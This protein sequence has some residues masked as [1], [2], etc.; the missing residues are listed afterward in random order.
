[1]PDLNFDTVEIGSRVYKVVGFYKP[2]NKKKADEDLIELINTETKQ[3][4]ITTY[5][6]SIY[7]TYTH[8][9]ALKDGVDVTGQ[10]EVKF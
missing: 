4:I 10:V 2:L 8:F 7:T 9:R 3:V 5:P 1:M 6:F